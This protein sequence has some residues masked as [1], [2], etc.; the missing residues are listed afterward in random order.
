[1]SSIERQGRR[2][3]SRP[4]IHRFQRLVENIGDSHTTQI[5]SGVRLI[6]T[7]WRAGPATQFQQP[8]QDREFCNH[9]PLGKFIA[10]LSSPRGRD[11]G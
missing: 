10:A 8:F 6:R 7:L 2:E 5:P 3:G 11:N 4:E 9:G 1:V